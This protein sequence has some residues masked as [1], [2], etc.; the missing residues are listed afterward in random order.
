MNNKTIEYIRTVLNKNLQEKK[1]LMMTA[2]ESGWDD[3][4]TK[5]RIK[6]YREAYNTFDE[7][8]MWQA[9]QEGEESE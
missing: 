9:E 7:F 2:I 8:H 4:R 3:V 6:E 5:E 1:S